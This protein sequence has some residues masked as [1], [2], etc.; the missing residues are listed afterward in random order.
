MFS[1]QAYLEAFCHY[2]QKRR[3]FKLDRMLS[4]RVVGESKYVSYPLT[5]LRLVTFS[6][7]PRFGEITADPVR[8][9]FER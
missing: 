1:R 4:T 3:T 9:W 8:S 7:I 6:F 5:A 2:R